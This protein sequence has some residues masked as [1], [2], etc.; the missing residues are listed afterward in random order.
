MAYKTISLDDV[1]VDDTQ[2][3]ENWS[4]ENIQEIQDKGQTIYENKPDFR[5]VM[6]QTLMSRIREYNDQNEEY[7]NDTLI[8]SSNNSSNTY[9]CTS[10]FLRDTLSSYHANYTDFDRR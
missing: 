7:S 5:I 1:Y 3:G 9:Y 8:C 4:E 10:T 2:I 6:T